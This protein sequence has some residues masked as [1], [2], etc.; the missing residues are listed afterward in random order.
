MNTQPLRGLRIIEF[1]NFIAGP[2]AGMLLADMGADVIKIE[3]TKLG[4]MCRATPPFIDG[5]SA[6][7]MSLNKN[8]K[9]I[10][11]DL[12]TATG[13]EAAIRLIESAD[14]VI[15][16]FRP[17]V[18][19]SLGLGAEAMRV[20]KPGLVYASVSGF[21]Q[22]GAAR[23]KAAVNLI[24]EAASGTL[25]VTGEPGQ[26]PVRPGIQTGDMMGA[27]FVTYAVLAGLLGTARH[28]EGRHAD[29][30]L[31]EASLA[32]AAFE[33]AEYLATDEVPQP[34]GNRHRL[35]APYQLFADKSGRFMAIGTPNDHLFAALREVLGLHELADDP[36]FATYSAR[37]KNE[38]ALIPIVE[39]AIRKFDSAQLLKELEA[40]GIPC[41]LVK[42]YAEILRGEEGVARK[43]VAVAP[44]SKLGTYETVRNP[45][46]MDHG[47][48][49]I[50]RGAPM[51]GEHTEELLLAAG[52]T[53]SEIQ[54]FLSDGVAV[55]SAV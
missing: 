53:A 8:K 26:M 7:F 22:T 23:G 50:H 45:I 40:R 17:G 36:R 2:F 9:S 43:I 34:L 39:E 5:E 54:R 11:L 6:S 25:S 24:I 52:Y 19:E 35:T 15:E 41:S 32:A 37:K 47:S 51:H 18:M 13:L 44:H 46:L 10:A 30:S 29:I 48:P 38:D 27:L 49:V 4:D 33:T 21:G 12:K 1:G 42:N 16:N 20:R 3:P 14:A 55:A 31:I 28:G